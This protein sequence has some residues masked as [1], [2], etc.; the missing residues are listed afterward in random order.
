MTAL[1]AIAE[2]LK[3]EGIESEQISPLSLTIPVRRGDHTGNRYV[4]I[5]PHNSDNIVLSPPW[6]PSGYTT[7][8]S[9]HSLSDPEVFDKLVQIIKQ[10]QK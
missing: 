3:E 8:T 10:S 1:E 6:A 5:L 4:L 2:I 9:D 7:G